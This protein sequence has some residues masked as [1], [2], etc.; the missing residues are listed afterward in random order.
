MIFSLSRS[1]F[2]DD[3]TQFLGFIYCVEFWGFS[4]ALID[5][6]IVRTIKKLGSDIKVERDKRDFKPNK[7]ENKKLKEEA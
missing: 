5:R 3:S 1:T 6:L 7:K 2:D 4:Q